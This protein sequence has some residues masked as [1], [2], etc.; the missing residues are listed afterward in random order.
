[1]GE[2]WN[3]LRDSQKDNI[4]FAA[5]LSVQL[6]LIGSIILKGLL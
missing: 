4:L 5:I 1:M 3:G 2:W 6:A